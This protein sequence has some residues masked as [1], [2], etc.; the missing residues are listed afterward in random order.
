[1]KL[2]TL[3]DQLYYST[4]MI[5]SLGDNTAGTAFFIARNFEG[6]GGRIYLVTNKHV[7]FGKQNCQIRFHKA[8][9]IKPEVRSGDFIYKFSENEWINGWKYHENPEVDLAVFNLTDIMASL[10]VQNQ[11]IFYRCLSTDMI[12]TKEQAISISAMERIFFVGYPNAFRDQ[13]NN[14]P[15]AR[16]GYLATPLSID[17]EGKETFLLDA[18]IFEGSSGSPICIINENYETYTDES[19]NVKIEGRY[20]LAGVN[21]STFTRTSDNEYLDLGYAWKAHKILEIM[22]QNQI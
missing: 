16:S 19:G 14:L 22:N 9:S 7:V 2:T 15:I 12:P 20:L 4:V 6:V 1:M 17:F 10:F 13:V 21:S 3:K 5:E 8:T 11:Y 18:S